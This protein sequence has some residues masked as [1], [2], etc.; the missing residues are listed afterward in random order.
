MAAVN[1]DLKLFSC[2]TNVVKTGLF[3]RENLPY[4]FTR[5]S[6]NIFDMQEKA[7]VPYRSPYH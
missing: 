7:N 5:N 4:D 2:F 3:A 1:R 6:E